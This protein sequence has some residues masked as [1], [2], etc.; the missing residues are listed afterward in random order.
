MINENGKIINM[1]KVVVVVSVVKP[2]ILVNK[3]D[4]HIMIINFGGWVSWTH[5]DHLN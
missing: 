1:V 3:L 4:E 2:L 5:Y